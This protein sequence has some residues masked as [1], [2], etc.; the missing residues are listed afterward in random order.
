MSDR[1]QGLKDH[2][3]QKYYEDLLALFEHPGWKHITD[4]LQELFTAADSVQGVEGEQRLGFR[5]GQVDMIKFV[6]TQPALISA[7]YDA[8]LAE[9]NEDDRE[10]L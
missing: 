8:L 4:K 1:P 6:V 5:Q 10:T 7:A 3:T 2:E 9:E